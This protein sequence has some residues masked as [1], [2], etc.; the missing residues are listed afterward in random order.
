MQ[1]PDFIAV[2]RVVQ[3]IARPI[4]ALPGTVLTVWPRNETRTLAVCSPG[5]RRRVLRYCSV[6]PGILYG[7]VMEWEDA[8]IIA[9][10]SSE[11]SLASWSR[12][13]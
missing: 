1:T 3:P 4:L 7:M 5:A 10:F 9:P 13:A 11:S 2:Y 12:S 6:A 8:G